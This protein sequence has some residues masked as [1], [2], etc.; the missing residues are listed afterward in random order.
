MLFQCKIIGKT[1]E[2]CL[3]ILLKRVWIIS[4][5]L[6]AYELVPE[7]YRQMF[8]AHQE[9][10][11]QTLP[12]RKVVFLNVSVLHLVEFMTEFA[13]FHELILV[14]EFTKG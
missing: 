8:R 11:T 13:V 5:V 7:A 4:V 3:H 6:W 12:G 2:L 1:L 14:E 10:P 9:S